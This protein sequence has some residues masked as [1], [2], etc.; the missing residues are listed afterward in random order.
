M[1]FK[2]KSFTLV[3]GLNT[4]LVSEAT[5]Y[6]LPKCE[7]LIHAWTLQLVKTWR[8]AALCQSLLRSQSDDMCD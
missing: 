7:M 3:N 2:C 5:A 6:S 4:S 8:S 1:H